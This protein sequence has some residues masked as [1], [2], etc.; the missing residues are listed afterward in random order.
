MSDTE[1]SASDTTADV[2]EQ[3]ANP[4]AESVLKLASNMQHDALIW[5]GVTM[6]IALVAAFFYAGLN[7]LIGSLV[8]GVVALGSVLLTILMMRKTA[9]MP[10]TFLLVIALGGYAGKTIVLFMVMFGLRYVTYLDKYSV[11]LTMLVVILVGAAAEFR[12]FRRTKIP[13]IIPA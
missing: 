4:H 12:A 5:I 7:G 8:G 9:N 6:V 2:P 3:P 13:T 11:A 1:T 10:P